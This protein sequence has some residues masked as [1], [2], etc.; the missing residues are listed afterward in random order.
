M[1]GIL[2]LVPRVA[3]DERRTPG[4]SIRAERGGTAAGTVSSASPGGIGERGQH[5]VDR[6]SWQGGGVHVNAMNPFCS[7]CEL[8]TSLGDGGK[9]PTYLMPRAF[10]S[11]CPNDPRLMFGGRGVHWRG[12]CR[13]RLGRLSLGDPLPSAFVVEDPV[14]RLVA[15][16]ADVVEAAGVPVPATLRLVPG[17]DHVPR[18]PRLVLELL[19]PPHVL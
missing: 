7:L 5:S 8:A 10:I 19:A 17:A 3:V 2:Y 11:H 13:L 9:T 4:M 15:P 1:I 12:A 16:E 14:A 18:A 6:R